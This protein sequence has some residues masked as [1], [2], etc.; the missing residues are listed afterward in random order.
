[1]K[2]LIVVH[3]IEEAEFVSFGSL[4]GV[5][6]DNKQLGITI[7]KDYKV[8]VDENEEFYFIS[9]N[10]KRL[11]EFGFLGKVHYSKSA[12]FNRTVKEVEDRRWYLK[13]LERYNEL[14]PYIDR[15]DIGIPS[16]IIKQA[17]NQN[18]LELTVLDVQFANLGL[19]LDRSNCHQSVRPLIEKRMNEIVEERLKLIFN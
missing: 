8:K 11:Y 13:T 9:D 6:G 17:Y 19:E 5:A 1:M 15:L 12:D 10:D 7:N 16:T 2:S 4:L 14:K 18:E 3:S